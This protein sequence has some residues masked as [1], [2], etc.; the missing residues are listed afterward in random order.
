[1]NNR[2]GFLKGGFH[3]IVFCESFYA[4]HWNLHGAQDTFSG[5]CSLMSCLLPGVPVCWCARERKG[6]TGD[7]KISL[8]LSTSYFPPMG[9]LGQIKGNKL[10]IKAKRSECY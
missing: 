9:K 2:K 8:T 4:E 1:M 3:L 6:D 7:R 5:L 10:Y